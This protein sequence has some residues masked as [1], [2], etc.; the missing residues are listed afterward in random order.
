M[1]QILLSYSCDSP[2]ISVT[3]KVGM[4][5]LQPA[6]THWVLRHSGNTAFFSDSYPRFFTEWKFHGGRGMPV[7][8]DVLTHELKVLFF[9]NQTKISMLTDF[10]TE[11]IKP[12]SIISSPKLNYLKSL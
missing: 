7:K 2:Y 6:S 4:L 8:S 12:S 3:K 10:V 9:Q 1:S 5:F 11:L